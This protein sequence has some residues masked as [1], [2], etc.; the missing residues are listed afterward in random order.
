VRASSS[1]WQA[2]ACPSDRARV[3]EVEVDPAGRIEDRREQLTQLWW[4]VRYGV[5]PERD[6]DLGYLDEQGRLFVAGREDDMIVSGGENVFPQGVE[7]ALAEHPQVT[8]TA[9]VGVE[10][11]EF[12]QRLAAFVVLQ[13]PGAATPDG[14]RA[15]LTERLARYEMPRDVHFVQHIPRN[16]TG[17]VKRQ[18]LLELAQQPTITRGT[19]V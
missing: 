1:R 11:A 17:K 14:L 2:H 13:R 12:G 16:P 3:H 15:Y 9:V 4:S 19:D 5:G 10:D 18:G 8:D 7:R 6:R